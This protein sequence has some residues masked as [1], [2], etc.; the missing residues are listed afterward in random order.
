MKDLQRDT[1]RVTERG[2]GYTATPDRG[3]WSQGQAQGQVVTVPAPE[4]SKC[5]VNLDGLRLWSREEIRE[6]KVGAVKA[7]MFKDTRARRDSAVAEVPRK[8]RKHF[9]FFFF[10]L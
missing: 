7:R 9:T 6:K 2:R 10:A 8:K 5:V 4:T 3:Q 1:F